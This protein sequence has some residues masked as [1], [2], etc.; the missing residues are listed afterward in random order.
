MSN[1]KDVKKVVFAGS[2]GG[3]GVKISS[4][5]KSANTNTV[6]SSGKGGQQKETS[7]AKASSVKRKISEQVKAGIGSGSIAKKKQQ[8][9]VKFVENESEEDYDEQ[10]KLKA[11]KRLHSTAKQQQSFKKSRVGKQFIDDEAEDDSEYEEDGGGRFS[12]EAAQDEDSDV[13]SPS[14]EEDNVHGTDRMN[15][16]NLTVDNEDDDEEE[17]NVA[18]T[19]SSSAGKGSAKKLEVCKI[20]DEVL[21]ESLLKMKPCGLGQFESSKDFES[22]EFCLADFVRYFY[23]Y[24]W[25]NTSYLSF[26]NFGQRTIVT[27]PIIYGKILTE[28]APAILIQR[29][30]SEIEKIRNFYEQNFMKNCAIVSSRTFSL[31]KDY[32]GSML[33]LKQKL[34][35]RKVEICLK[36][37]VYEKDDEEPSCDERLHVFKVFKDLMICFFQNYYD[38]EEGNLI[39]LDMNDKKATCRNFLRC[40]SFALFKRIAGIFAQEFKI[41]FL[42]KKA[43]VAID[44]VG[45]G[46]AK[47]S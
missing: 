10:P 19:S 38:S 2:A 9:Q 24:A 36:V 45:I 31:K 1:A 40:K 34:F 14:Y 44:R 33:F 18:G 39:N 47:K 17:A 27:C 13:E 23:T 6:K 25:L 20:Y 29:R 12:D 32:F 16:E 28:T 5:A 42:A 15:D 41:Y 8:A 22:F 43:K 35:N 11:T 21:L 4:K 37:Y 7:S 26:E 46:R 30:M 3:G